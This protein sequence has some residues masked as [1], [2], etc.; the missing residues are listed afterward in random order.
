MKRQKH[1]GSMEDV[2]L[3]SCYVA[4]NVLCQKRHKT[5]ERQLKRKFRKHFRFKMTSVVA[6]V[7][8]LQCFHFF[9]YASACLEP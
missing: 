9:V 4:E 7:S 3:I 1:K 8:N 5:F 6:V 2:V